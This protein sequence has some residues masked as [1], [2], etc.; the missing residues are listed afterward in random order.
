ME[1]AVELS[2][3]EIRLRR[4]RTDEAAALYSVVHDSLDHLARFMPWAADRYSEA[5]AVEFLA[6]TEREWQDG[7]A[8]SYAIVTD[9]DE[10]IG[11]CG[12]MTRI[13]DGG[14]EI[15]YWLGKPHTGRGVATRATALLVT[16]AFRIGANRVEIR[17]D[18]ANERSGLIP[19]RLGFTRVGS[20]P[21]DL[22][23]G[24]GIHVHWRLPAPD[25]LP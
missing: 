15:G 19:A 9:D 24:T 5:D 20:A 21:A 6:T 16:E 18:Q 11:A 12:L 8:F 25:L 1:P 13:G 23:G 4:W 2:D 7:E 10:I 17:H 22:A 14:L 3:G